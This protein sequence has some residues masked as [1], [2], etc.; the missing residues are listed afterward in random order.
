MAA[1]VVVSGPS[2][3]HDVTVVLAW[4]VRPYSRI[5]ATESG[6]SCIVLRMGTG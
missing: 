4:I 2:S 3:C 6:I 5:L 1:K